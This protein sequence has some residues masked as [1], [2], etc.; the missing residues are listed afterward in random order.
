MALG[1]PPSSGAGRAEFAAGLAAIAVSI[2]LIAVIPQLRHCVSLVAHGHLSALRS[3]VKSLGVGG[4]ALLLG[5]MV[6]HAVV[7]YPS[8]IV[9]TTAGYVFGF[10]AGLALAA[11]GWLLAA[12][13]TY[14]LGRAVGGP[15]LQRVLGRRFGQL[16]AAMEGGGIS[17]L[18]SGRLIPFIP[19]AIIGYAAGATQI[20]LWRF[21]WTTVV[22]YLPLTIA[23]VYLGSRAQTL[24]TSDPKLWL[25][26][27]VVVAAL[28]GERVYRRRF[29]RATVT[30]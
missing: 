24:S 13:L 27:A 10:G 6:I 23:V 11:G 29:G 17:L 15:V 7:W 12:L 2:A 4:V 19:F 9:T 16:T 1:T 14:A 22:G 18:L 20:S 25:A 26:A 28:V 5:L 30:K 3:Y 21:A 8:E